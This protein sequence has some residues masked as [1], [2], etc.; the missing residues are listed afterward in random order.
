M[1][2][3]SVG[4]GVVFAAVMLM[5]EDLLPRVFSG[6]AA[7][8]AACAALWPIFA[9]MQPLNG[10]V[11]AL[12]G[13]LIGA[14]DGRYLMW[15]M[16]AAFAACAA[17]LGAVLVLDWGIRGVW[18]ALVALIAVRLATLGVR[19]RSRRWAVTGWA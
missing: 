6:D 14:G 13:I 16:V 12:D 11:F 19:F 1:I 15:S 5:L 4:A 17:A 10:A 2:W 8:L 7:V 3:L 9:L 18:A